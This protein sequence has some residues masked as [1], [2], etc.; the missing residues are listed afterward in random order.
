[1]GRR[2]DRKEMK[3][4]QQTFPAPGTEDKDKAARADPPVQ[5]HRSPLGVDH[6]RHQ[7]TP[8]SHHEDRA[9]IG[10][11]TVVTCREDRRYA[12]PMPA[13]ALAVAIWHKVALETT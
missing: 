5:P 4:S 7:V 10:A 1:M 9:L 12:F 6:D 8:R 3:R 2:V 11:S 13:L